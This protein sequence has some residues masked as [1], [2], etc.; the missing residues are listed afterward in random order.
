MPPKHC[1]GIDAFMYYLSRFI[2]TNALIKEKNSNRDKSHIFNNLFIIG[3]AE[4]AIHRGTNPK[5]VYLFTSE[6]FPDT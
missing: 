3:Q 4:K 2:H 6:E 1:H 5:L